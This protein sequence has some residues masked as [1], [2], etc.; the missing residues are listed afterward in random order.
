MHERSPR[1]GGW[2]R[3]TGSSG[4]LLERGPRSMMYRAEDAASLASIELVTQL[5]LGGQVVV[6]DRAAAKRFLW[7][8]GA[9]GKMVAMPTG[10]G[11]LFGFPHS[12]ALIKGLMHEW[13]TPPLSAEATEEQSDESVQEWTTR[14]LNRFGKHNW[15]WRLP[16]LR[17]RAPLAPPLPFARS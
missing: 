10:L 6:A 11:S 17:L 13:R 1:S 7:N 9:G 5:G 8:G 16:A 12:K 14:R 15:F 2:V 4:F 3:T